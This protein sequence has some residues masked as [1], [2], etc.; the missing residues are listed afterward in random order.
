MTYIDTSALA[1]WYLPEEGSEEV[2]D[3]IRANCPLSI[4]LLTKVEMSS[5]AARRC[6]LGDL[7]AASQGKVLATFEGDIIAG[8][9][10]LVPQTV[11]AFLAAEFL[12]GAHPELALTTLDALHLGT[13]TSAGITML[14]TADTTM[15]RAA[16]KIGVECRVFGGRRG[17]A[18]W[19]RTPLSSRPSRVIPA[20]PVVLIRSV[21]H[22]AKTGRVAADEHRDRL[23]GELR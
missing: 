20:P 15:A 10:Q 9:L 8:H 4:S 2:E 11:E 7:D 1:K 21:H 6:R 23:R 12:M 17:E 16:A 22:A 19:A 13:M 14:A 3:Y 5:L 18:G